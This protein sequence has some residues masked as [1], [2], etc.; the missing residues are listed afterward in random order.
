MT[1]QL[2][3]KKD[4][5]MLLD[6]KKEAPSLKRLKGT[7]NWEPHPVNA[8]CKKSGFDLDIFIVSLNDQ[9]KV[10]EGD[11]IVYFN[12]KTNMNGSISVPVDNQTGEGDDDEYFLIDIPTLRVDRVQHE[13]FVFLHEA[14]LRKQN[15]GM[16]SGASFD[17]FD[18]ETG[19]KIVQYSLTQNYGQDT[20][21]HVGSLVKTNTG[22]YEFHPAG[23]GS[24][25][26][27]QDVINAYAG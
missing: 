13:V 12:N 8:N 3:L 26:S 15:F 4:P 16:I 1:I 14:D 23:F 18:D 22:G 21:L 5:A 19:V 27:P 7:L 25:M 11:D 6:L 9:G 20:A 10:T 2:D 24:Q 17:L